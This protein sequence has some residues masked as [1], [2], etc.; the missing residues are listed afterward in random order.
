MK[1]SLPSLIYCITLDV[2]GCLSYVVPPLGPIWAVTSGLIFYFMFGKRLGVFGGVF[3][4]VEEMIPGVDFI[5]T[6]TI[7]WYLRKKELEKQHAIA[8]MRVFLA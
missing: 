6:F 4:F 5:P 7:S 1:K 8:R 3:S 2:I